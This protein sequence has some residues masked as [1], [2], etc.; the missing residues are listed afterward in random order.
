MATAKSGDKLRV[1]YTG[2]LEDGSEFDS[3]AGGDP[4]EFTLGGGQLIPGFET[5]VT[6]M[7]PGEKKT[8]TIDAADAY[9]EHDADLVLTVPR[10]QIPADLDPKVGEQLEMSGDDQ[11]YVVTV[12]EVSDESVTLDGNHPLAGKKLCFELELVEI[13]AAG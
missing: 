11:S 5:G 3:S 10:A 9:G 4:L 1:H 12:T 7:S 13:V 6:G 8:I 2:K